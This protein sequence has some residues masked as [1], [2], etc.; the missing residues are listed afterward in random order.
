[1]P[2][3][4]G[5]VR[6]TARVDKGHQRVG[7]CADHCLQVH[8]GI[9]Q[10]RDRQSSLFTQLQYG[11]RCGEPWA[12]RRTDNRKRRKVS[13]EDANIFLRQNEFNRKPWGVFSYHQLSPSDLSQD[14]R[15]CDER[16][17]C[18]SGYSR[19]CCCHLLDIK[20]RLK[21]L[22]ILLLRCTSTDLVLVRYTNGS[23]VSSYL[24]C[25]TFACLKSQLHIMLTSS[26]VLLKAAWASK[27]IHLHFGSV[28]WSIIIGTVARITCKRSF[29][30]MKGRSETIDCPVRF[31]SDFPLSFWEEHYS[32]YIFVICTGS[33]FILSSP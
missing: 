3:R 19:G 29:S 25:S 23:R 12:W 2:I 14:G 11:S 4:T 17:S 26:C 10:R 24:S 21:H 20:D 16:T 8:T 7:W 33:L 5:P 13:S 1:M 27:D 32:L 18:C 30:L 9:R 22:N 31:Y 6:V 28:I 15:S